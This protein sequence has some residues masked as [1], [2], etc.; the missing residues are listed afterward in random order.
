LLRR[1]A[2]P[3][4]WLAAGLALG[5]VGS[6]ELRSPG[7]SGPADG[8][9]AVAARAIDGDTIELATGERVRYVGIDTPEL[10]RRSGTAWVYHPEPYAEQAWTF[11]RLAVEGRTVRLE[12]DVE[13]RDRYQ[14]RLAYVY[15]D[16]RFINADLV[17]KGLADVL[18]IPPNTRYAVLFRRLER[19]AHDTHRGVWAERGAP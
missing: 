1:Q 4:L 5:L 3:V 2:K 9:Y 13:R 6:Q 16:D 7:A 15:R 17:A 14:R 8:E 18:T 11:N 10:Y 19:E 12:Y